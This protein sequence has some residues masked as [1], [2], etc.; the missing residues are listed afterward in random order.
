MVTVSLAALLSSTGAAPADEATLRELLQNESRFSTFAALA[1]SADLD[2]L[3]TATVFAPTNEAFDR[4]PAAL[5]EEMQ[6]T[7]HEEAA[8]QIVKL[9]IVPSGP[10]DAD[11]IPVEM[12]TF[13]E[14]EGLGRLVTTYS[15]GELTLQVPPPKGTENLTDLLR[16]R[17][18][19]ET[20]VVTGNVA[21][22]DGIIVHAIDRVLLPPGFA[23]TAFVDDDQPSDQ[24]ASADDA[25]TGAARQSDGGNTDVSA[26]ETSPADDGTG[27]DFASEIVASDRGPTPAAPGGDAEM[28][29]SETSLPG[30][31]SDTTGLDGET[32]DAREMVDSSSTVTIAPPEDQASRNQ[33]PSPQEDQ[34][35]NNID[36]IVTTDTTPGD[37]RHEADADMTT[38]TNA[39]DDTRTGQEVASA[40]GAQ[41]PDETDSPAVPDVGLTREIVSTADLIGQSAMDGEGNEIGTISDVLVTLEDARVRTVVLETSDG[42]LGFGDEE[43]RRVPVAQIVIDPLDGSVVVEDSGSDDAE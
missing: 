33:D 32:A 4:L 36:G 31:D 18:A 2:G 35:P 38:A 3:E 39:S 22:Q 10:H 20:R 1:E 5:V 37:S 25:S 29:S 19:D 34:G 43:T 8:D 6:G 30:S 28:R 42:F 11:D 9:H 23:P 24:V 14:E 7:Q 40:D 16:A 26:A 21:G 41:T 17:A 13:A 15:R 12:Q 27:E